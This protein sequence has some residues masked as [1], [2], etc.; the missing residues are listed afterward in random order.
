M[1]EVKGVPDTIDDSATSNPLLTDS[2]SQSA[3][4]L[5]FVGFQG[6]PEGQDRSE[7]GLGLARANKLL[8]LK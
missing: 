1:P 8:Q 5:L 4:H 3:H 2:P 7:I 6:H